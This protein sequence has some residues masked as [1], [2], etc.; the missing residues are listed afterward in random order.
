MVAIVSTHPLSFFNNYRLHRQHCIRIRTHGARLGRLLYTQGAPSL[1][2]VTLDMIQTTGLHSQACSTSHSCFP[3]TLQ[4][5]SMHQSGSSQSNLYHKLIDWSTHFVSSF[6]G[7]DVIG[8]VVTFLISNVMV[9]SI[10]LYKR[11]T[12][13][14]KPPRHVDCMFSPSSQ[15]IL[16]LMP[17]AGPLQRYS[18]KRIRLKRSNH[19]R[20]SCESAT[21]TSLG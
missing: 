4:P 5:W 20:C 14:T 13:L 8:Y 16:I 17:S 18:N 3:L 12:P 10:F 9:C 15:T 6:R 11:A 2:S 7:Y 19:I 1:E 21:R